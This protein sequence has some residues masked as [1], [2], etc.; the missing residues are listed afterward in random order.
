M[1]LD[2]VRAWK[3]EHYRQDLS[4]DQRN[5]MP[6]NPA[7]E[8]SE[9]EMEMVFGGGGGLGSGGGGGAPVV[10]PAA[11]S[12]HYTSHFNRQTHVV[13]ATT[14]SA[15]SQHHSHS[16]VVAICDANVFSNDV[17]VIIVQ[18]VLNIGSPRTENCV[19]AG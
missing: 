9:A 2:I 17:V 4:A 15:A 19:F 11:P 7:G 10:T 18:N 12:V 13:G 1:K 8:L 5:A 16:Y 3:D 14:T 6:A